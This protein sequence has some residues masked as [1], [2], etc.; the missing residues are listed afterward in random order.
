M[1][2][3]LFFMF[4]ATIVLKKTSVNMFTKGYQKDV[5]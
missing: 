2:S 5:F 4:T 3:K 1:N